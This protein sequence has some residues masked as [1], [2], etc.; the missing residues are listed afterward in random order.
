MKK[1][2]TLLELLMV[3]IILGILTAIALPRYLNVVE[4]GKAAE[5]IN[6]L[7]TLRGSQLR[8][9]AL[10]DEYATNPDD[11]D[12]DW[13]TLKY[14]KTVEAAD[15]ATSPTHVARITRD[16]TGNEYMLAIDED[17]TI[18]CSGGAAGVCDKLGY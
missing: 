17:G 11:L 13:T 12:A 6:L 5:A 14:F 9:Y 7:G 8:Y 15:S 16:A 1:G 18:S 10:N 3:V 4:R 2:F